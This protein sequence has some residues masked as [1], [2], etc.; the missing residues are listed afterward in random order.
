MMRSVIVLLNEYE[1]MNESHWGVA[2]FRHAVCHRRSVR[3]RRFAATSL[4][5]VAADVYNELFDEFFS[6]A[7]VNTLLSL[8]EMK[9]TSFSNCFE[10]L[11]LAWQ[12]APLQS[13]L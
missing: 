1:W 12:F 8:N 11:N 10:Q 5:F 6:V 7:N 3:R 2:Q 13:V 9:I 4:I